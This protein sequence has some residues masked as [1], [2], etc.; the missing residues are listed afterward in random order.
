MVR[1]VWYQLWQKTL[2]KPSQGLTTFNN[3][4]LAIVLKCSTSEENTILTKTLDLNFES[5]ASAIPPLRLANI[6]AGWRESLNRALRD[7]PAGSRAEA[8]ILLRRCARA[9]HPASWK[10]QS[11]SSPTRERHSAKRLRRAGCIV[12]LRK[13]LFEVACSYIA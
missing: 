2:E 3:D 12:P 7:Q 6:L 5:A 13:P 8:P 4:F 9:K 1:M 11:L 10:L